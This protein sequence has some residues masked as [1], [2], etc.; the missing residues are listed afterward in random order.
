ML[1][2][3]HRKVFQQFPRNMEQ[4][5]RW[6][7]GGNKRSQTHAATLA[8]LAGNSMERMVGR[9]PGWLL[10]LWTVAKGLQVKR[11]E[12]A[13]TWSPKDVRTRPGQSAECKDH[14]PRGHLASAHSDV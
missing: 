3:D 12:D 8:D 10:S 6:V 4:W 5:A 1:L 7:L 2:G 13:V 14:W 11:V 9:T